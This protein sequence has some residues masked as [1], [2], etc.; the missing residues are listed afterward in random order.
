MFDVIKQHI[1]LKFPVRSHSRLVVD[2]C[3]CYPSDNQHIWANLK[4]SKIQKI[5]FK[6]VS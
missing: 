6:G 4:C 3:F 5:Y 2:R 1:L